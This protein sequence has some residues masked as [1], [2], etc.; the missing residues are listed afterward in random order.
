MSYP[1]FF[2]AALLTLFSGLSYSAEIVEFVPNCL[3][4]DSETITQTKLHHRAMPA[5]LD[6]RKIENMASILDKLQTQAANQGF[7]VVILNRFLS[8]RTTSKTMALK[9]IYKTTVTAT[10]TNFCTGDTSLSDTRLTM[11]LNQRNMYGQ[12]V[13]KNIVISPDLRISQTQRQQFP[14]INHDVDDNQA[15]GI[16]LNSEVET[17]IAE[18]GQPDYRFK[19]QP[20]GSEILGYGRGLSFVLKNGRVDRIQYG[21]EFMGGKLLNMLP[22]DSPFDTK[23]WT[24]KGQTVEGQAPETLKNVTDHWT[25]LPGGNLQ[26]ISDMSKLELKVIAFHPVD[27]HSPEYRIKGFSLTASPAARVLPDTKPMAVDANDLLGWL[28]SAKQPSQSVQIPSFDY[29]ENYIVDA[30]GRRWFLINNQILLATLDKRVSIIKL[31]QA[32]LLS[33]APES[34]NTYL[35]ALG[36]PNTKSSFASTF[37]EYLDYYDRYETLNQEVSMAIYFDPDDKLQAIESAVIRY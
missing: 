29:Q 8:S 30:R 31:D 32:W 1:Y 10:L 18:L 12:V 13:T 17:L 34:I 25:K 21:N 5:D 35:E 28:H 20:P 36:V 19:L 14:P 22:S 24:L 9:E 33:H 37:P 7:G 26:L 23:S 27:K 4:Q 3:E 16:K 6:I 2:S 15:F 11:K